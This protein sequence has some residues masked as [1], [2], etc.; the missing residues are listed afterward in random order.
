MAVIPTTTATPVAPV[1]PI[2]TPPTPMVNIGDKSYTQ[3]YANDVNNQEEIRQAIVNSNN[4]VTTSDNTGAVYDNVSGNQLSGATYT[5]PVVPKFDMQAYIQQQ[6][7]T[8]NSA[9]DSAQQARDA[10]IQARLA[11]SLSGQDGLI[12][13][14]EGNLVKATGTINQNTYDQTETAKA[15]G[16]NRGIQYSQQQQGLENGVARN[17]IKMIVDAG[18]ERDKAILNIKDRIASLKSGASYETQASLATA[19]SDKSTLAMN[20]NDKAQNRQW[21]LDDTQASYNRQD[22]VIQEQRTYDAKLLAENKVYADKIL[23]EGYTR[24]DAVRVIEMTDKVKLLDIDEAHKEAFLQLDTA[25]QLK[26][27]GVK[28]T[29]ELVMQGNEITA[30]KVI[31]GMNNATSIKTANIGASA[32]ITSSNISANASMSNNASDNATSRA[33]NTANI[34][35]SNKENQDRIDASTAEGK[36]KASAVTNEFLNTLLKNDP[37]FNPYGSDAKSQAQL[38]HLA[39]LNGVNVSVIKTMLG[40]D[41]TKSATAIN[42]ITK[43]GTKPLVMS[44]GK[45]PA[46]SVYSPKATP[47]KVSTSA[48]ANAVG[49]FLNKLNTPGAFAGTATPMNVTKADVAKVASAIKNELKGSMIAKDIKVIGDKI[50]DKGVEMNASAVS[51]FLSRVPGGNLK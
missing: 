2:N 15:N 4:K 43:N 13:D 19:N 35:Q 9:I 38:S 12:R 1:Q 25:S 48:S 37:T 7:A 29:H 51:K 23:K 17:G 30:Q 28:N 34:A 46:T 39:D 22:A 41:T 33:N 50:Y 45:S 3:A 21:T 16:V 24:E 27:M 11:E 47:A 6:L 36:A 31:T 14:A 5:P 10:M 44:N 40:Q 18:Q 8:G 49:S 42:T 20:V 26:V 32:Q